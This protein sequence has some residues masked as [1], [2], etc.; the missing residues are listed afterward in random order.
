MTS[1]TTSRNGALFI[2]CR[3]GIVEVS[4]QDGPYLSIGC[5]SNGPHITSDMRWTPQQAL[6]QLRAD[7]RLR[8]A[9]VNRKVTVDLKQHQ[10]DALVSIHY[11]RGNR[12][13]PAMI[14]AVN[15]GDEAAVAAL[16]PTLDTN[17]KGEH[18]AGLK[19]RRL[20]ELAMYQTGNYGPLNSIPWWRG[21]PRTTPRYE[22]TIQPEDLT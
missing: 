15:S 11:N 8:E 16:F 20:A 22:Y 13:F 10:F 5:G 4:Y 17:S 3:E 12:D 7:L 18:L 6:R 19:M 9:D 21:P 2:A 1:L 14:A